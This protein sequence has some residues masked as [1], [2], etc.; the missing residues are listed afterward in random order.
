MYHDKKKKKKIQNIYILR[1]KV[2]SI[3]FIVT[4]TGKSYITKIDNNLNL[5]IFSWYM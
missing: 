1:F 3:I 2:L 4:S 5:K